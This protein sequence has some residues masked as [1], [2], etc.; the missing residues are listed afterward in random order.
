MLI[1][2]SLVQAQTDRNLVTAAATADQSAVNNN[3]LRVQTTWNLGATAILTN[4]ARYITQ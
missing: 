1:Y 2:T 3:A 4:I